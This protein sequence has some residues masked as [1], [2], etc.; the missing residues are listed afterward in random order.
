[1]IVM[2]IFISILNQMEFHMVWKIERKTVTY[3]HIYSSFARKDLYS[4]TCGLVVDIRCII[5]FTIICPSLNLCILYYYYYAVLKE[6]MYIV[7]IIIN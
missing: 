6:I 4:P 5:M 1:M 2:T 3:D 7:S